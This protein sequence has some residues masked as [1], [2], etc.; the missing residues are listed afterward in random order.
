[1]AVKEKMIPASGKTGM[2]IP[3]ILQAIVDRVPAPVGDPEA[4]LQALTF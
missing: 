2:G 3:E 4:P 1:M